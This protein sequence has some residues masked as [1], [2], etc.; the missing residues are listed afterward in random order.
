M[1]HAKKLYE[2]YSVGVDR[3][4]QSMAWKVVLDNLLENGIKIENA[5]KLKQNVANWIRRATVK[6]EFEFMKL[7][8]TL[9]NFTKFKLF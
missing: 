8:I 1:K 2:K 3:K 4:T 5:Q 9:N 6:I 7:I